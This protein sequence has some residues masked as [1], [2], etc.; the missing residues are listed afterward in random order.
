MKKG[1]YY[2]NVKR[3]GEASVQHIK[4]LTESFANETF[5]K[6]ICGMN[7]IM[8]DMFLVT[9]EGDYDCEVIRTYSESIYKQNN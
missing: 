5:N 7:C 3:K 1:T 9:N 4:N 6:L 2:I 8:I